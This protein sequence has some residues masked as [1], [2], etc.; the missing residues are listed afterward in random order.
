MKPGKINMQ[1]AALFGVFFGMAFGL[2]DNFAE[3]GSVPPALIIGWLI[4]GAFGGA[5]LF[6]GVAAIAN[7]FR[8]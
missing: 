8:K 2:F 1:R 5:L 4:G 6:A 3:I 7:L